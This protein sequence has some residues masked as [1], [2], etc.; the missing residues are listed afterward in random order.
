MDRRSDARALSSP[1]LIEGS[2]AR[3]PSHQHAL[4]KQEVD[5]P[6]NDPDI[7]KLMTA[8]AERQTAVI[9]LQKKY[10]DSK[11]LSTEQLVL[12]MRELLTTEGIVLEAIITLFL[13]LGQVEPHE[14]SPSPQ[15]GVK[16]H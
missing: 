9:A 1:E 16:V 6:M 8:A 3:N 14:M 5:R 4:K 10:E 2:V 13:K 12:D 15:L 7:A 11:S